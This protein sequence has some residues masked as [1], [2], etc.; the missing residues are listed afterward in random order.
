MN[1]IIL[2]FKILKCYYY[3][4]CGLSIYYQI[5]YTYK[6]VTYTGDHLYKFNRFIRGKSQKDKSDQK[7]VELIQN[8]R[9]RK[10][11]TNEWQIL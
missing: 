5:N 11:F 7:I 10:D 6:V 8:D 2:I 3:F 4:S 9:D 1:N